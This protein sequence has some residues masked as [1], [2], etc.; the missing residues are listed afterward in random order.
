MGAGT[1]NFG[2]S[3][4][5]NTCAPNHVFY[6]VFLIIIPKTVNERREGGRGSTSPKFA[7]A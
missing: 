1:G 6:S 5:V 7:P 4:Q 2:K 3:D